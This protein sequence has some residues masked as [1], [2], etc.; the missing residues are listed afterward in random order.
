MSKW[1]QGLLYAFARLLYLPMRYWPGY[2]RKVVYEN[3]KASFPEKGE[4]EWN[5]LMDDFYKNLLDV[6]AETIGAFSLSLDDLRKRGVAKGLDVVNAYNDKGQP[7]LIL[8]GH[9]SNWEWANFICGSRLLL[10]ADPVYKQIKNKGMNRFMYELRAK[11]GVIP[12]EKDGLP[13]E[14][15]RRRNGQRNVGMLSDQLPA[16]GTDKLWVDFLGRPTAFYK[17]PGQLAA[18]A[19]WPVFYIHFVRVARG[20]YEGEFVELSD[21]TK[22]AEA[23]NRSYAKALER[24]IREQPANWLWSHKRWKYPPS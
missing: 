9:C 19:G 13:R 5:N 23:I 10:P 24:N 8:L 12:I 16:P 4:Q 6:V 20:Q 15:V 2:R 14:M 1:P 3:I 17:G 18:F 22:D 11:H 7:V 21:G